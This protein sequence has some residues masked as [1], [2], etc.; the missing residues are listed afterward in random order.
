[1]S[2]QDPD[3]LKELVAVGGGDLTLFQKEDSILLGKGL[4]DISTIERR[5]KIQQLLSYAVN[6]YK[7]KQYRKAL[8]VYAVILK[9]EKN[10][11]NALEGAGFCAFHLGNFKLAQQCLSRVSDRLSELPFRTCQGME[12]VHVA[13]GSFLMGASKEEIEIASQSEIDFVEYQ[14]NKAKKEGKKLKSN[15][16]WTPGDVSRLKTSLYQHKVSLS[17]FYVSNTCVSNELF[18]EFQTDYEPKFDPL[19]KPRQPACLSREEAVEFCKWLSTRDG[20]LYRLP[21]EAEWE[22]VARGNGIK[23]N[24][25]QDSQTKLFPD[26]TG[27]VFQW[28][29]DKASESYYKKS[30]KLDPF[31]P[32]E[33]KEYAVK[34]GS[35]KCHDMN[36]CTYPWAR[37]DSE[38]IKPD[39]PFVDSYCTNVTGIRLVCVFDREPQFLE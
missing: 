1:M 19:K 39:T 5:G 10:S 35:Y 12:M 8:K 25:M 3:N 16:S 34:G 36:T 26:M 2:R 17:S 23:N 21:T 30:P 33:G 32:D 9:N 31:G 24:S 22:Y 18:K 7:K 14:M 11:S 4:K 20:K 28:C 29:L 37:R 38:R 15:P 6:F 13:G 27:V